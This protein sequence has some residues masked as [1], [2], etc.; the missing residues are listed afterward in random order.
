MAD[1]NPALYRRF[2][3]ERTRPADELLARVPLTSATHVVDLGCGPGNSTELLVRRFPQ[4]QV[5]GID[6][7]AAM[8]ASARERLPGTAFEQG[9]IATWVPTVAPD[10]I[11]ANAAL[12]W[13]AW[14]ETLVPRLFSLLAP[15]GVLAIQMPD[16][17]QEPSHRLMRAVAG[18]APWREPIGD[19]DAVRTELATIG[20]YYDMLAREAAQVDVWHTVYQHVM[21]TAGSIVDWL[22]STGLRPFL[23]PLNEELRASF[24]AEY[25]RRIAEVYPERS[26]GNRLL[27][28]PRM[29]IVAQ[30]RPS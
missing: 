12:Q 20:G 27:A 19:A 9:D 14:H 11:Y 13:V 24:L 10:L 1:W 5:T 6:T 7:S 25:E 16:N 26:D 22:R 28:F 29:F 15:G 8:L 3:D 2:E 17:R 4:A 23:D 21:P 30:R 18:E